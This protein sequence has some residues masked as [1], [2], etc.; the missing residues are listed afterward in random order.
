MLSVK[1]SELLWL[2]DSK[3]C[4]VFSV[5]WTN[6]LLGSV[7]LCINSVIVYWATYKQRNY[8]GHL[9]IEVEQTSW[10]LCRN[11]QLLRYTLPNAAVMRKQLDRNTNRN[12]VSG[13]E[14]C[15]EGIEERIPQRPVV[16]TF[17]LWWKSNLQ[18]ALL[19]HNLRVYS[20]MTRKAW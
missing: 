10:L 19:T 20:I 8:I 5:Y 7:F 2:V 4:T 13:T 9:L 12:L 15:R 18:R 1:F 16:F 17:L 11:F 3:C 14:V 6:Y